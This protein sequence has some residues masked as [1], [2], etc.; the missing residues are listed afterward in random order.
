MVGGRGGD[1]DP[2][3]EVIITCHSGTPLTPKHSILRKQMGI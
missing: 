2:A 3:F 1:G